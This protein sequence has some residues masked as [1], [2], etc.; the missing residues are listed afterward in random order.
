MAIVIVS[1][2]IA[3]CVLVYQGIYVLRTGCIT[4]FFIRPE[5][6]RAASGLLLRLSYAFVYLFPGVAIVV[7]LVTALSRAG[8]ARVESWVIGNLGMLIGS[9]F[10]M[11]IGFLLLVQPEKML[12]WT[13]RDHP[14]LAGNKAA[15]VIARLIGIGLLT[16]GGVMLANL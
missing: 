12:L 13:I 6:S 10:F 2:L 7:I 14:E 3:A 9:L 15:T 8:V 1:W 4:L 16:M 11:L 5:Y